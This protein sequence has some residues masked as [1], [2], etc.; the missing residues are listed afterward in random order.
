MKGNAAALKL[1]RDTW[2]GEPNELKH[3]KRHEEGASLTQEEWNER[4]LDEVK[5]QQEWL[6]KHPETQ[7]SL[8]AIRARYNPK[9]ARTRFKLWDVSLNSCPGTV[10]PVSC[11][12][13]AGAVAACSLETWAL[14]CR[15]L[16][17]AKACARA[18]DPK[19]KSPETD[20]GRLKGR[21]HGVHRR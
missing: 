19:L 15:G 6:D 11:P 14:S 16:S 12:R 1:L 17:G 2:V 21:L 7:E 5:R 10:M 18:A 9:R 4:I 8:L 3:L 13:R 20:A